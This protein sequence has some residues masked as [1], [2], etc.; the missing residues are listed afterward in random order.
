MGFLNLIDE[1]EPSAPAAGRGS[2]FT[3]SADAG[4]LKIK[5]PDGQVYTLSK[6]DSH[7][8]YLINGGFDFAQRQPPGTATTYRNLTA[9]SY[10]A[11]RWAVTNESASV[12]Y[13]RI[14]TGRVWRGTSPRAA[15]GGSRRS[16][17][18]GSSSS[19]SRVCEHRRALKL[20]ASL[21]G[22]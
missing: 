16:P 21:G 17:A 1:T 19:R 18:R 7:R 12:T 3:D 13:Q 22:W 20:L 11:D 8:N 2:I 5:R 14:D 4:R 15:T 6:E 9:R 10:T